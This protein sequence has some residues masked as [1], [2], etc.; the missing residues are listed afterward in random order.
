MPPA[1]RVENLSKLYRL[2]PASERSGYRTL[3]EDLIRLATSPWRWLREGSA[4]PP[5][6]DFW[7][8]RDVSFDVQPGEVVGIIGRN[9]AGKST[10]LKIVSRITR[11]SRGQVRLR[12]RVGSLLEVGTGFHP[13]L[14]GRENVHLNGAILGM[15]R[16]E[17][18][19]KFDEIVAF[20]EI[21]RFLDVPVKRYSSGMSVRLAF[22][23]AAHLE[24][25]ILL[26]DE[27]LAVGDA[28]FQKKCI[29]K[30]G[31]VAKHGRTILFV[32]H[33]MAAVTQLCRRAIWLNEGRI[34]QEGLSGEVVRGYLSDK[35]KQIAERRWSYPGEAPG[36]DRVRLLAGRVVQ[37]GQP[38]A[39]VDING[40]CFVEMEFQVLRSVRNLVAAFNFYNEQGVCLFSTADWRPNDLPP[41]CY[42]KHVALPAQLFAEGRV[43]VLIQL[44][45]YEPHIQSAIVPDA[46]TFD[47]IDSDHSATVRGPFYKGRWPGVV[48]LALDWSAADVLKGGRDQEQA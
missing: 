36:D 32:S 28:G 38:T 37:N 30:M 21:D 35:T 4:M 3:R 6:E 9:G 11:P 10:L 25:E 41:G 17:I 8:L 15:S 31:E 29:G 12:G 5:A 40:P 16:N 48:R 34:N 19:R 45:F 44:V 20:A 26:M 7:A 18:R 13:E 46:L 2:R 14:S 24:P 23:V 43:N 39:I 33:N 1:I 42:T 22:A 47:T 27:V